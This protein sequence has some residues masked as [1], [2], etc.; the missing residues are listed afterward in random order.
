MSKNLQALEIKRKHLF[1]QLQALGDFRPGSI[2]VN[3]RRCGKKNCVCM[4]PGHPGHGP[5]FLWTTTQ[6][7]HSRAQNLRLGPELEK[8][9]QEIKNYQ[10][11]LRLSKELVAVNEQI[12]RCRPAAPLRDEAELLALKKTLRKRFLPKWRRKSTRSL[13][14]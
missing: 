4:Q 10:K 2:S 8:A 5:Q 3:Y 9:R 11:F 14:G 7:G 1:Q 12:C 6:G 13:T